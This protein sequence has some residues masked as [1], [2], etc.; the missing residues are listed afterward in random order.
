MKC[1]KIMVRLTK[2]ADIVEEL[3]QIAVDND[4]RKGKVEVIG[5]LERAGLGFYRQK[6]QEYVPHTVNEP[7]ELLAGLG[8]IS[9]KDGETFVHL[10]LTLSGEDGQAFGGHAMQGCIVFAGEAVVT[11]L[12][13]PIPKRGFDKATG[14]FLWKE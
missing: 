10:H 11:E 3:T 12:P 1:K 6:E 14:L 9:E 7:V 5:A 4:I 8:N 13:G 2:G